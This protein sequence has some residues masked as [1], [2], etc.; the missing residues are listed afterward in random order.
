MCAG[1]SRAAWDASRAADD[2]NSRSMNLGSISHYS[3]MKGER[4][5]RLT[6]FS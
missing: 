5:L 6:I 3:Q 2:P 1:I 4:A